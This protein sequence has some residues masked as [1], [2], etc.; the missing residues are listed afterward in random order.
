MTSNYE[1]VGRSFPLISYTDAVYTL[2]RLPTYEQRLDFAVSSPLLFNVSDYDTMPANRPTPLDPNGVYVAGENN[3]IFISPNEPVPYETYALQLAA[4][5]AAQV[6]VLPGHDV[7]QHVLYAELEAQITNRCEHNASAF[8]RLSQALAAREAQGDMLEII[9]RLRAGTANLPE[10]LNVI[11]QYP[12]M[13]AIET[14]NFVRFFD[15]DAVAAAVRQA[16]INTA[17]LAQSFNDAQLEMHATELGVSDSSQV[18]GV[19]VQKILLGSVRS[20]DSDTQHV[21]KVVHV[22]GVNGQLEPCAVTTYFRA[23]RYKEYAGYEHEVIDD[24]G[25]LTDMSLEG[26]ELDETASALTGEARS[27]YLRARQRALASQAAHPLLNVD[28]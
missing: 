14:S 18:G 22:P 28:K 16:R 23:A 17:S 5:R 15:T 7:P 13:I 9:L 1:K 27:W 25:G 19:K 10:M 20:A 8:A 4:T 26:V 21:L 24:A 11:K 6:G 3:K 2:R 12:E